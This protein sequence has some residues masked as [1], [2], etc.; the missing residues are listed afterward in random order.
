VDQVASELAHERD[1]IARR[2][3]ATSDGDADERPH[4]QDHR[5]ATGRRRANDHRAA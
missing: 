2:H 3:R 1:E 5:A 4:T